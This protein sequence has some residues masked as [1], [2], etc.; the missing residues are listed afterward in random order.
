M[1]GQVHCSELK[2]RQKWWQKNTVEEPCSPHGG[3]ETEGNGP[4]RK[5]YPPREHPQWPASSS[6]TLPTYSCTHQTTQT[7]MDWLGSSSH[8]P[9]VSPLNISALTQE[10]WG[11][12]SYPS[13]NSHQDDMSG[14][15]IRH[16]LPCSRKPGYNKNHM[17]KGVGSNSD[18]F[19]AR[20]HKWLKQDSLD[21]SN[22]GLLCKN[23][24]L[25][26]LDLSVWRKTGHPDLR[27]N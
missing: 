14:G 10:I 11:D 19:G 27:A 26:L 22:Q 16:N 15:Y 7:R 24:D 13:H 12:I 25:R 3:H 9:V 6:R 8:R 23:V 4:T 2:V 5:M 1:V 21:G 17:T 20:Y 18:A